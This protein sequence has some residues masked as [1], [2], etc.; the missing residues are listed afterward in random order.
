VNTK[1]VTFLAETEKLMD[2]RI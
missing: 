2:K 1:S